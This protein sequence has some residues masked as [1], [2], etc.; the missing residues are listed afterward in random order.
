MTDFDAALKDLCTHEM[1]RVRADTQGKAAMIEAL[2]AVLAK[3]I[4]ITSGADPKRVNALLTG[5][6][7]YM[8]ELAVEVSPM[9]RAFR[10]RP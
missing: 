2:A 9:V 3:A 1:M 6:D 10:E 8:T 5:V 7:N 4:V